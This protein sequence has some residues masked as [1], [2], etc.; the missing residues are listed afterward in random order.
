MQAEQVIDKIL[1]DARAEA[2]KI[3]QQAEEREAAEK[4][5]LDEEM[6]RFE[7]ETQ[8]LAKKAAEDE[9]SQR[10]AVARMEIAKEYLVGKT[11]LLGEVFAQAR[12]RIEKLPDNEYGDLMG[13]LMATAVEQGDEQVVAGKNDPRIDQKL[14]GEVNARLQ[15][16]GKGHLTLSSDK[17]NIG[18]G[19]LLRRGKIRTNVS[20]G[21]LLER[22]RT[23]LEIE[24]AKDLFSKDA[25]GSQPR[26]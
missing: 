2:D 3:R 4:A 10:L 18:G 9:R 5:K 24:L 17:A 14:V 19:F 12:E 23:D 7:R 22:A 6:A 21:V 20:I 26:K 16:Q 25:D 13:R 1:S 11:A 15:G 8:G